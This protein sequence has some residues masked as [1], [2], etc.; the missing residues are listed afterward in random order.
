MD[1]DDGA[2]I[3]GAQAVPS[4]T[5]TSWPYRGSGTSFKPRL[6]QAETSDEELPELPSLEEV[7]LT[8][9]RSSNLALSPAPGIYSI[10]RHSEA[11]EEE[12]EEEET[13]TGSS[14]SETGGFLFQAPYSEPIFFLS[15]DQDLQTLN[16][17]ISRLTTLGP[18]TY[19]LPTRSP[20]GPTWHLHRN[21]PNLRSH[22]LPVPHRHQYEAEILPIRVPL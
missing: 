22:A 2:N 8:S 1:A 18:W 5:G 14:N 12:T 3:G 11:D 7:A 4:E 20:K 9:T 13:D 15:Q 19:L 10:V 16:A 17:Q 6:S 21:A